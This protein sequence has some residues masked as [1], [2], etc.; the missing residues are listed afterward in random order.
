MF[1]FN[2][3]DRRVRLLTNK[4]ELLTLL[5]LRAFRQYQILS[6]ETWSCTAYNLVELCFDDAP[7]IKLFILVCLVR[8]FF[9]FFFFFLSVAWP[10]GV[11]LLVFF[12]SSF[13]VGRSTFLSSP[14]LCF[15]IVFICDLFVSRDDPLM[16]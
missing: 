9:F 1:V 16:S 12:C 11:Q 2:L 14:H 10:T 6:E 15:I 4:P 13:P 8:S 3:V 5:H 7:D